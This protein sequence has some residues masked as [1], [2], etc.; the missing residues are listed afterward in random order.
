MISRKNFIPRYAHHY[1]SSDSVYIGHNRWVQSVDTVQK[2]I[3][4]LQV[5]RCHQILEVGCG[6]GYMASILAECGANVITEDINKVLL[7]EAQYTFQALGLDKI[8][9]RRYRWYS[10]WMESQK[11]DRIVFSVAV[12]SIQRYLRCL[13]DGGRLIAPII[14]DSSYQILTLFVKENGICHSHEIELVRFTVLQDA[15]GKLKSQ[16]RENTWFINTITIP[17][18]HG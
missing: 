8:Q 1:S 12:K 10:T 2:V 3:E 17:F 11:Y 14:K 9:T 5:D 13:K 6:S 7:K 15:R 16:K 4:S 18:L